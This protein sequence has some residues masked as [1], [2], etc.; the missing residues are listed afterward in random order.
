MTRW[1]AFYD[2]VAISDKYTVSIYCEVYPLCDS[3]L[4]PILHNSRNN[5]NYNTKWYQTYQYTRTRI[6]K[7]FYPINGVGI[8]ACNTI[9]DKMHRD[10]TIAHYEWKYSRPQYYNYHCHE[11]LDQ[12]D[13]E[14]YASV[15]IIYIPLG[16]YKEVNKIWLWE[17][18]FIFTTFDFLHF[19]PNSS[20]MNG[21]NVDGI[22][23]NF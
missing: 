17:E 8:R 15:T 16:R 6:T 21:I 19:F 12:L 13:S 23:E 22:S 10:I 2:Y 20:H 1:F 18:L 7:L 5:N 4:P 11:K 14:L 9:I 3:W